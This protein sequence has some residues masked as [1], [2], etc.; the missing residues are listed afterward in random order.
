MPRRNIP[1]RN[2][3]AQSP[4]LRKGGAHVKS[5]T[6]QRVRFRL[7]TNDAV[8]DWLDELED[9]RQ[10]QEK[11]NG[12]QMLPDFFGVLVKGFARFNTKYCY[13]PFPYL[14]PYSLYHRSHLG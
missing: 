8:D 1:V 10:N 5:K 6:G 12:E 4:L 11:E 9:E 14:E 2:P 3:V 7:S 13:S